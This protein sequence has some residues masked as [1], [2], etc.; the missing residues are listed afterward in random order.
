MYRLQVT[1]HAWTSL[2][3]GCSCTSH[4]HTKLRD[5]AKDVRLTLTSLTHTVLWLHE[6]LNPRQS[7]L[8][9]EE[10]YETCHM[11]GSE[12]QS[13]SDN[14]QTCALVQ[15]TWFWADAHS[16]RCRTLEGARLWQFLWGRWNI[17]LVPTFGSWPNM[18]NHPTVSVKS[19]SDYHN[20]KKLTTG[21]EKP[22]MVVCAFILALWRQRQMDRCE[23]KASLVYVRSF[24]TD[25]AS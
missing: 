22:G 20:R 9:E 12:E 24:S 16:Q 13:G 8:S 17:L 10:E 5:T 15:V 23:F 2:E 19:K 18:G 14:V 3:R 4:V 6:D 7:Q 1:G 21:M 25:R 11:R